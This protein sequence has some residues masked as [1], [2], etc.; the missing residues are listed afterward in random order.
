MPLV[1]TL[2][3]A[4][5]LIRQQQQPQPAP[6][7]AAQ[8]KPIAAGPLVPPQA[9]PQEAPPQKGFF[10][11]LA[12]AASASLKAANLTEGT[13]GALP[14]EP[15]AK[16]ATQVAKLATSP[17]TYTGAGVGI[18]RAPGQFQGGIL[19]TLRDAGRY[20]A[21]NMQAD[22]VRSG[23]P[24]AA[25]KV[26]K[27]LSFLYGGSSLADVLS[28]RQDLG[29]IG[30]PQI[31]QGAAVLTAALGGAALGPEADTAAIEAAL[32]PKIGARAAKYAAQAAKVGVS[33]VNQGVAY[34][35]AENAPGG[36]P[37][38]ARNAAIGAAV[39]TVAE[40][41]L[42][43]VAEPIL[44]AIPTLLRQ[45]GTKVTTATPEEAAQDALDRTFATQR[46]T[47]ARQKAAEAFAK[48]EQPEG[49]PQEVTPQGTRHSDA[50]PSAESATAEP[51]PHPLVSDANA[52]LDKAGA[53]E[54]LPE[55]RPP[56]L[57]PDGRIIVEPATKDLL[58]SQGS[59][60]AFAAA[61]EEFP[62][63]PVIFKEED[64]QGGK[65]VVGGHGQV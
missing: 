25:A 40:P 6:P 50:P 2:N 54:R 45:A 47:E 43:A 31:N 13:E 1:D 18:L 12:D 8:P 14:A 32:V 27:D 65:R 3:E 48:G 20:Q 30:N 42:S 26:K 33:S 19:D 24:E 37:E 44:S 57:S 28:F 39:N 21:D 62:K 53:A 60:R 36:L 58:D 49:Q 22:L 41:L 9:A 59:G 10:G 15:T 11:R 55:D 56:E 29:K 35:V 17:D 5:D 7:Q 34:G 63:D 23:H 52:A 61:N 64:A 16:V 4:A 46:T 51:G 38:R